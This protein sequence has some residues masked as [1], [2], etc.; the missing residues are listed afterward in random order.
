MI[1]DLSVRVYGAM[2]QVI[3]CRY[4]FAPRESLYNPSISG[5]TRRLVETDKFLVCYGTGSAY[6][7]EVPVFIMHFD[8]HLLMHFDLHSC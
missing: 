7:S 2:A 8:L 6:L 4:G 3:A 5:S 1:H